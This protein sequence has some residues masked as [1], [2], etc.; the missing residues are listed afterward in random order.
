[1]PE[2]VLSDAIVRQGAFAKRL[3]GRFR[4]V[5]RATHG[6]IDRTLPVSGKGADNSEQDTPDADDGRAPGHRWQAPLWPAADSY[7]ARL[8]HDKTPA[9]VIALRLH[10][11]QYHFCQGF[12]GAAGKAQE[13]DAGR[14]GAADKYQPAEVPVFGNQNAMFLSGERNH[15]ASSERCINS[16][17]A[18]TS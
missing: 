13:D 6:G 3:E 8:H 12:A 9:E 15:S 16:L 1:M 5:W 18:N 7:V 14:I 11:S 2:S 10:G 4:S 17:T